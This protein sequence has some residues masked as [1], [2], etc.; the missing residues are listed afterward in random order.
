M[1]LI[2]NNKM[3]SRTYAPQRPWLIL[4]GVLVAVLVAVYCFR[5]VLHG[6]QSSGVEVP[7]YLQKT[8]IEKVELLVSKVVRTIRY[9]FSR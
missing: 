3:N 4:L 2:A 7:G 9:S 1:N 6:G 8:Q 5:P